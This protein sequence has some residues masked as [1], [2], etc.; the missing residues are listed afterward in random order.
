MNDTTTFFTVEMKNLANK[1]LSKYKLCDSCLGRLFAHVDKR[2]T[3]KEK[4][5]KLRKELNK[6]NVSPK[7]C[8]LCEGLTGEINELADI[9]EKKLQEY[10]F[11]TFLI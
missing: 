8:W 4:G 3:N 9:V 10:E 6:K 2:V 7:N 1:I 11:S 5:E